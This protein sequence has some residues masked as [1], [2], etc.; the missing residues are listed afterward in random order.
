MKRLPAEAESQTGKRLPEPNAATEKTTPG[1]SHL[2]FWHQLAFCLCQ[3]L[4][5]MFQRLNCGFRCFGISACVSNKEPET[6]PETAAC[7]AIKTHIINTTY[8]R[9]CVPDP[10]KLYPRP[11]PCRLCQNS[12]SHNHFLDTSQ[13]SSS[14]FWHKRNANSCQNA[15][16][17]WRPSFQIVGFAS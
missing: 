6:A 1:N 4:T 10:P 3:L 11:K 13:L 5:V 17:Y 14:A 9:D 15:K 8:L 16:T 12:L 7:V 2:A